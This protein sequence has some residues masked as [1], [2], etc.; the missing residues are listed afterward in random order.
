MKR[1]T[2]QQVSMLSYL[3]RESKEDGSSSVLWPELAKATWIGKQTPEVFNNRLCD[4]REL[5]LIRCG[6][7]GWHITELGR[8]KVG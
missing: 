2:D 5:G 3:A 4:L 6:D 1:L 8:E 7:H